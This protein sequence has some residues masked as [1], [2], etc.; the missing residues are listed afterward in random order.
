V[1]NAIILILYGAHE[2]AA[3]RGVE[4][5]AMESAIQRRPR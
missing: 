2:A 1:I 5:E 3:V 4:L